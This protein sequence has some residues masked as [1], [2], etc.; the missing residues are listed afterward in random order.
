MWVWVTFVYLIPATV[1]TI[2]ILSPQ[3]RALDAEMV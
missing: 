2:Q 3:R 1:V